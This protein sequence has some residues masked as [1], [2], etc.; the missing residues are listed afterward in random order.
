MSLPAPTRLDL[1][2]AG[3]PEG[4]GSLW[5]DY[6]APLLRYLR[7]KR[8][9]AAEDVASQV[10]I[11]VA[12]SLARFEGGEDDFKRW[13]FTIAHRRSVDAVR[14]AVRRPEEPRG[15]IAGSVVPGADHA[16]ETLTAVDRALAIVAELPDKMAEAVMLQVVAD[17]SIS[18][19]AAVMSRSEGSVR[20]LVHRGLKQLAERLA[21]PADDET[22]RESVLAVTN[23]TPPTMET[24]S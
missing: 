23:S 11:D 4:L 1:A 12:G 5:K 15:D 8:T 16:Y 18:D 9:L 2:R 24:L 17:M 21:A 20:V 6:Q 14:R 13:L 10:W 19:V 7:A 3:D 22:E